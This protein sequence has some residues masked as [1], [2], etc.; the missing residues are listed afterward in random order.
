MNH[1]GVTFVILP[2]GSGP[3]MKRVLHFTDSYFPGKLNQGTSE[4]SL[5][6]VNDLILKSCCKAFR[7]L[8]NKCVYLSL[9]SKEFMIVRER[10]FAQK[11]C[12]NMYKLY[13][14]ES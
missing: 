7:L 1:S 4:D 5:S 8:E 14:I 9:I 11:R 10:L 13:R 12:I 6:R 3:W 2:W